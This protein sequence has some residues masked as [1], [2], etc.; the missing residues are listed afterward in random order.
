MKEYYQIWGSTLQPSAYQADTY[1]TELQ[2]PA[3]LIKYMHVS[4]LYFIFY[5]YKA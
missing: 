2:F 3:H 5:I 1:L 4:D